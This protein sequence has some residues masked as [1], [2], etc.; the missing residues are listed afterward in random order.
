MNGI[1]DLTDSSPVVAALGSLGPSCDVGELSAARTGPGSV[2]SGTAAFVLDVDPVE[3]TPAFLSDPE[4]VA[5]RLLS[6]EP[7]VVCLGEEVPIHLALGIAKRISEIAPRT[8]TILLST[9]NPDLRSKASRVGIRE[10][11]APD[12]GTDELRKAIEA[13][14]QLSLWLTAN[15]VIPTGPADVPT[16]R[17]V[18]LSPK[19]GSG[20]T[21]I[22][23]NV[24]SA[25]ARVA[26]GRVVV[27]DFDC[28]FG[29]VA[30]AFGLEPERTLTD[31]G[32]VLDLD[33]A[34]VKLFLTRAGDGGL[35]VLPSSGSPAEAD[36]INEALA[37]KI[38][39]L[40]TAEFDYVIVD[41]AAGID[42]RSLAAVAVATDIVCVASMDVMGIRNLVKEL[43]VLD[44]LGATAPARH[45]VLNNYDEHSGLKL[46]DI[47]RAVGLP[48]RFRIPASPLVVQR[49]N[50]GRVVVDSDPKSAIA[51]EFRSLAAM[52]DKDVGARPAKVQKKRSLLR[53]WQS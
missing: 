31:L 11:V 52:F 9:P 19:G 33:A 32:T 1:G 20:K 34:K 35:Y 46:H 3:W 7:A 18:V 28:Q 27:V 10:I 17:I 38:L 14:L 41:T 47:E 16:K 44:R 49:A 4:G 51:G 25:L 37:K 23:V 29:D 45:F 40:L 13:S 12:A 15:M 42:D 6:R 50:E 21:T 30:T 39:E 36:A 43:E 48:A 24:A 5:A 26:P 53:R 8:S 22:A 2:G